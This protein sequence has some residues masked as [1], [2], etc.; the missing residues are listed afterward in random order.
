[1]DIISMPK[2]TLVEVVEYAIIVE[3]MLPM[4]QKK[5]VKHRQND[6]NSVEFNDS[7]H[8]DEHHEK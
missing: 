7:N 8:E 2:R 3:K 4:K 5:L 6:S 1:M